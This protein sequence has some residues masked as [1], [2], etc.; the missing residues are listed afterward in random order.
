M[1]F[2]AVSSICKTWCGIHL[3]LPGRFLADTRFE[4]IANFLLHER[5]WSDDVFQNFLPR[6]FVDDYRSLVYW[7]SSLFR[8]PKSEVQWSSYGGPFDESQ[9]TSPWIS[10]A[11]KF[12][13]TNQTCII[14]RIHHLWLFRAATTGTSHSGVTC[15]IYMN[16]RAGRKQTGTSY[17]S[18]KWLWL[19]AR[20]VTTCS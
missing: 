13:W 14:V 5:P 17:T 8:K 10:V 2:L 18:T 11:S 3:C 19:P 7:N 1:W 4:S 16:E 20:N 6:R 15:L 9:R 12:D